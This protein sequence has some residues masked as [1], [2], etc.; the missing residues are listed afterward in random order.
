VKEA[1]KRKNESKWGW[2][3]NA[4][5]G[6]DSKRQACTVSKEYAQRG[7]AGPE[8]NQKKL[9]TFV[10]H[11]WGGETHTGTGGKIIG[12]GKR[13]LSKTDWGLQKKDRREKHGQGFVKNKHKGKRGGA[14]QAVGLRLTQLGGF[15]QTLKAR[16]LERRIEKRR[17]GF[18]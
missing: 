1:G 11:A 17:T 6:A 14:G 10:H 13:G 9:N 16:K 7:E 18:K 15:R 12:S 2:G 3:R 8:N 4:P 5:L